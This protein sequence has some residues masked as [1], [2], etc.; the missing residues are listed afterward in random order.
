[1]SVLPKL[2][3]LGKEILGSLLNRGEIGKEN[4]KIYPFGK[5]S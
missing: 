5:R 2:N 4:G 3:V 1:M